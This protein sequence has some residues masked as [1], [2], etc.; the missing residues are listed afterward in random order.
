MSG[1]RAALWVEARK[2]RA[3][4]VLHVA[5]VLLVIGAAV[6]SA[7]LTAAVEAG[8]EQIVAKLGQAAGSEGWPLL[9]ATV[10]QIVAAGAVLT[11]GLTLSW[12]FGR[13][14]TDGTAYGLCALPVSR[15]AQVVAKFVVHTVWTL[16]VA[17]VLVGF[18]VLTGLAVGL[19]R[20]DHGDPAALGRLLVLCVLGGLVAAPAAVAA[21]L[22]RGPMPGIA[23]TVGVIVLAQ[24]SVAAAPA[25]SAWIPLAA[26][27]LWAMRP[28]QVSLAQLGLT[29]VTAVVFAALTARAWSRLELDR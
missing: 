7:S 22:G 3:A 10:T 15:T 20:P 17:A 27:A 23:A 12:Q 1:L 5:A 19:G 29:A 11:F 9:T 26:P 2:A 28:D 13:E 21:T 14:F 4:R 16:A 25:S 24:V 8:N 6:L 18:V